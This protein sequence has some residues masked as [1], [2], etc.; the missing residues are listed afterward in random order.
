[1]AGEGA[2][3]CF[4]S[5]SYGDE[6]S[7]G[8]DAS[9]TE[10][11]REDRI[12]VMSTAI[13]ELH[14]EQDRRRIPDFKEMGDMEKEVL[15][16]PNFME[17]QLGGTANGTAVLIENQD[18]GQKSGTNTSNLDTSSEQVEKIS[19]EDFV[20]NSQGMVAEQAGVHDIAR[21]G[22]LDNTKPFGGEVE[23][24]ERAGFIGPELAKA[25]I[26]KP[27]WKK[28][29]RA[30]TNS[31]DTISN[32]N[33]VGLRGKRALQYEGDFASTEEAGNRLKKARSS[34]EVIN[35][36]SVSVVAVEQPRRSQ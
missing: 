36:D 16:V 35:H 12:E 4:N 10:S 11:R 15:C 8:G 1:V 18:L 7:G 26:R 25:Q 9:E 3:N 27:T 30:S 5:N 34:G 33:Q 20:D 28:R 14:T 13:N 17:V 22:E 6:G 24:I 31:G 29:A 23:N 2:G 19:R 21:G 32:T